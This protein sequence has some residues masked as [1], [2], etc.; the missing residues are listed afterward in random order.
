MVKVVKLAGEESANK[1]Q[2][3]TSKK[4]PANTKNL[5]LQM[6]KIFKRVVLML[7]N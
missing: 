2:N 6:K 5:V 1:K 3:K 4:K 7:I